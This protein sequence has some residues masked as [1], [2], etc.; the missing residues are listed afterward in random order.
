MLTA[1][2]LD[3]IL[4]SLVVYPYASLGGSVAYLAILTVLGSIPFAMLRLTEF[5]LMALIG[6]FL[7]GGIAKSAF[8]ISVRGLIL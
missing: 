8:E 1:V 4:G 5:T 3:M 6:G 2:A 7:V